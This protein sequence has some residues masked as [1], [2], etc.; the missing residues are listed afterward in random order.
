M[1]TA[2]M[3]TAISTVARI[4]A[5]LPG[6][7]FA[8]QLLPRI[9]N[10]LPAWVVELIR[11]RGFMR[12]AFWLILGSLF[13]APL[14]DLISFLSSLP[15][16]FSPASWSIQ[17]PFTL[18]FGSAPVA[19]YLILNDVVT[20]IVYGFIIWVGQRFLE[21]QRRREI[22]SFEMSIIE[23]AFILSTGGAVVNRTVWMTVLGSM[24]LPFVITT[25]R[26]DFGP[27]GFL[28]SWGVGLVLVLIILGLMYRSLPSAES[29]LSTRL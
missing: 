4:L 18:G 26:F 27:V 3:T 28:A 9:I 1:P 23:T 8:G 12:F 5:V 11:S 21:A 24:E 15:V 22:E 16:I 25:T 10:V 14:T 13:T 20:L 6:L 19:W 2:N 29:H 7:W 17:E